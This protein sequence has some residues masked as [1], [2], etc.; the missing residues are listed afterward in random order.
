MK[1]FIVL[2]ACVALARGGLVAPVLTG[3][4]AQ[5]R[6]QDIIGN[7]NFGYKEGHA[8][9]GTFRQE[10]GDAWGNKV[11]SY[12]LQDADGRVRTVKYVA[13]G[14]GFR[15]HIS[16]NEP[17]TAAG[18]SAAAIVNGPVVAKVAAPIIAAPAI[19]APV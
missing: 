3:N 4:S 9:G 2:F 11:G 16:T 14:H 19:A 8:T 17:G 6:S 15:A 1:A 7:Y 12:G 5:H 13:D 18:G 10:A